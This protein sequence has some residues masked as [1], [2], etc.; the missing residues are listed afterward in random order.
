MATQHTQSQK[1]G[2]QYHIYI[3]QLKQLLTNKQNKYKIF[4]AQI[5]THTRKHT[6]QHIYSELHT[7]PHKTY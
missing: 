3:N 7:L 1:K 6:Y 5:L 4:Q 2:K